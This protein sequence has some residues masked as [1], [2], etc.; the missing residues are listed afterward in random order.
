VTAY[1]TRVFV[2]L[3]WCAWARDGP[4]V[5]AHARAGPRFQDVVE[6]R[7]R[8]AT[9]AII[10]LCV[11]KELGMSYVSHVATLMVGADVIFSTGLP[12]SFEGT[13]IDHTDEHLSEDHRSVQL[14]SSEIRVIHCALLRLKVVEI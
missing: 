13:I 5:A 14:S 7:R 4:A 9:A 1:Y 6:A 2:W 11:Q 8:I 3:Q 12:V 10:V